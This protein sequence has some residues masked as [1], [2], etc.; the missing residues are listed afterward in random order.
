MLTHTM[1]LRCLAHI[2]NLATQTLISTKS[3]S[4]YYDPHSQDK[5][6]PDIDGVVRDEVGLVRGICV[7]V[8]M[9]A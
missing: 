8:S 5:H 1:Y 4:K 9:F 6:S 7:K 2:I 3:K